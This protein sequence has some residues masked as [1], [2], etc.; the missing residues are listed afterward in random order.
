LVTPGDLMCGECGIAL[1]GDD[2]PPLAEAFAGWEITT[3]LTTSGTARRRHH[4]RRIADGQVGFLTIYA[5]GAQPD[6]DVYRALHERIPREHIA[7]L[8]ESGEFDGRAYDVTELISG[9]TLAEL[10]IDRSDAQTLRR[11]VEELTDALATFMES[12]LRHRSLH[13]EKILVRS[14]E[15]L[16]LVVTGFESARLSEADLE[17]ESL[18]DFSRFTA[19]EAMIGGVASASDW[20]SVGMILLDLATAG[21]CFEGASDQVF[22]IHVQA[23]GAPIPA[24]MDPRI[25]LLLRGLLTIDRTKRWQL[26]EVRDWLD[27]KSPPVTPHTAPG[28]TAQTGPVIRLG[29]LEIRDPRIFATT[30]ATAVHWQQACELLTHGQLALWVEEL[31]LSGSTVAAIRQLGRRTDPAV[32]LRL[33]LALQHLFPAMPLIHNE[34]LVT[35]SWLLVHPEL[36][37]ELIT[38]SIPESLAQLG[39]ASDG[40]LLRL[41]TRLKEVRSRAESL[42]IE[43]DE[44][45]LHGI[46]LI[47]S[48][49]KLISMWNTHRRALPDANHAAL[50]AIVERRN[51]TDEDLVLLLSAAVGQFR[52]CA[53]IFERITKAAELSARPT[54][55]EAATLELLALPRKQIYALVDDR[56]TGFARCGHQKIDSWAD[57]FRLEHRLPLPEAVLLLAYPQE[58]WAKPKHQEYVSSVIGFF[59]KRVSA[60]TQRGPL[61]R[62]TIGKTTPRIDMTELGSDAAKASTLLTSL[63]QRS[64]KRSKIDPLVFADDDGPERRCRTLLNKT[65]QYFR[66]TGVNGAYIGFPFLVRK[67]VRE[68]TTPRLAPILLWPV[69]LA[70]AVGTRGDYTLN[71]DENRGEVRVNPA[72][73]GL[74]GLDGAAKWKELARDLMS[75]SSLTI[76]DVVGAF[77][78]LAEP[79]GIDLEPL[80]AP[81]TLGGEETDQILCSAVL[82]HVEFIG[83]ALVEDLRNLKQRPV[84]ESALERMLRIEPESTSS[85]P[86]PQATLFSASTDSGSRYLVRDSDPSQEEAIAKAGES[87][88]LLIQGPPGT[89]KSQTIVN[90]VADSVGHGRTVLIVCQKLPALEVVRKR[91]EA[92]RLGD[93]IV[94]IT[95]VTKDRMPVL[96]DIRSQLDRL[97]HR[98][99]TEVDRRSRAAE[100]LALQIDK[101]EAEIDAYYNAGFQ[102]DPLNDRTHRQILGELIDVE[103]NLPKPP[104]DVVGLRAV[105]RELSATDVQDVTDNCASVASEWLAACYENSPLHATLAF[106]HDAATIAEYQHTFLR[107]VDAE[108]TRES[109]PAPRDPAEGRKCPTELE[110]WLDHHREDLTG[111]SDAALTAVAPCLASFGPSARGPDY[112]KLLV[113]ANALADDASPPIVV[114]PEF[115]AWAGTITSERMTTVAATCREHAAIWLSA[116]FE[117]SPLEDVDESAAKPENTE[118]FRDG[119]DRLVRAEMARQTALASA[120]SPVRV[121]NPDL[122]DHW[123]RDC[124]EEL[125]RLAAA[126]GRASRDLVPPEMRDRSCTAYAEVLERLAALGS[127][128]RT[129]SLS[130]QP[131]VLALAAYDD[132]RLERISNETALAADLWLSQPFDKT[133]VEAIDRFP[134]S[135]LDCNRLERAIERFV[136][137]ERQRVSHLAAKS[138]DITITEPAQTREWL[139]D[140]DRLLPD[141]DQDLCEDIARWL[142]LYLNRSPRAKST[143]EVAAE[144]DALNLEYRRLELPRGDGRLAET[145]AALDD[146]R[147]DMLHRQSAEAVR[148]LDLQSLFAG[149][150]SRLRLAWWLFTQG[151]PAGADGI[152]RMGEAVRREVDRRQLHKRADAIHVTLNVPSPPRDWASLGTAI[153]TL[154]DRFDIGLRVSKVIARCPC[155]ID[156]RGLLS[157]KRHD[158]IVATVESIRSTLAAHDAEAASLTA[159]ETIRADMKSTWIDFQRLNIQ[160]EVPSDN[161][162]GYLQA[163]L[164]ALPLLRPAA[165]LSQHLLGCDDATRHV[166][167]AL[168]PARPLIEARPPSERAEDIRELVW[169][170]ALLA[171]KQ[172][173]ESDVPAL[174]SLPSIRREDAAASAELLRKVASLAPI[175]ESCPL[176]AAL[177]DSVRAR[178]ATSVTTALNAFQAGLAVARARES[179]LAAFADTSRF[180]LPAARERLKRAI[181]ADAASPLKLDRILQA[182]PTLSAY[183]RFRAIAVRLERDVRQAFQLLSA[184]RADIQAVPEAERADAI[185]RGML[186]ARLRHELASIEA[187]QPELGKLKGSQPGRLATALEVM[188]VAQLL[189]SV[190]RTCPLARPLIAAIQ[191]GTAEAVETVLADYRARIDRAKAESESLRAL[192]TLADWMAPDWLERRREAI[193]SGASSVAEIK[194]LRD[195][196]PTLAA[197]QLFRTR[198]ASLTDIHFKVF[199]VLARVRSGLIHLA[200]HYDGDIGQAIRS[201]MQRESLLAWKQKA[202][203]SNAAITTDSKAIT[204]KVARL[205]SLDADLRTLNR[206]RLGADLPIDDVLASDDWEEITRLQGPR[207]LR[208]RQFFD[209]GREYGLL[210]LRPVWMMTPD[211]ASQ[212][213]PLEKKLFDLV[214]FDEASQMPVEYAI[215]SLYRAT[216]AVVSGDEKQ[217]P[218]SSFFSSRLGL[219]EPE[220]TDDD[221]PEESASDQERELLEQTWNRREVKDCPDLLHLGMAVLPKATLQ[222]HYRSQYRELIAFSNA[223]FYRNELGVPVRHPEETIKITKP[224]EYRAVGG[225]YGKQCNPKEAEAVVDVVA[226]LW[227]TH[228]TDGP[229]A[230]IVTFNLKQA[231]LIE[232]LLEARAEKD[233]AFRAVYA[234]E[235]ERKDGGEDMSFFVKNVENVQGDERDLIIFSTTFGKRSNGTFLRNF[236]VLGQAGGERRLNV[237]ITRARSKIIVV[238]S[239]PIDQIS[240]MLRTKRKPEVPRD[241]LQGFLQYASLLSAGQLQEAM[242]LIDRIGTTKQVAVAIDQDHDGFKK[243]VAAFIRGLGLDPVPTSNDPVLG[244]DF[245]IRN[246]STGLFSVAVQCDPPRHRLLTRARAREIWR[247]AVLSRTY[248]HIHR[249]TAYAWYQDPAG[250]RERLRRELAK[251]IDSKGSNA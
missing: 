86:D 247:P 52:S 204:A 143:V 49:P 6:R 141:A 231:D 39:V 194:A 91:L 208:L 133:L 196:L 162:Q 113:Q 3:T 238:G 119:L 153:S 1:S 138:R 223:A 102:R 183:V 21:A 104:V 167:A 122:L 45:R 224:I 96:R 178:S 199:E 152:R 124:S 64:G 72:F 9:G 192:D 206:E 182:V 245:S 31:K 28:S 213:L 132:Q 243:S 128:S 211:I 29:D 250:E 69:T 2:T 97:D 134:A 48:T 209:R 90:L 159:L 172:Q 155:N 58:T 126:V 80:P 22:L 43:L 179:S 62:M 222:I 18:I 240:D 33:G 56:I 88:G 198:S 185:S 180:L 197:F 61:V 55:D 164:R 46:A 85:L 23:N 227:A 65:T 140:I 154:A 12:G 165:T 215:P 217:M 32:G 27:G 107:F 99:E 176:Q 10:A 40:F 158:A 235:R 82:F 195:A 44:D 175:V 7:E 38:S 190:I 163:L 144:L 109:I 84:D 150:L 210:V 136:Q 129:W 63:L 207:A 111:W 54:P 123:L 35:P 147:L 157:G 177:L 83:Q 110:A 70:G 156:K 114:S 205:G 226:D 76:S 19:P 146:S 184:N 186:L 203:A 189:S 171:R 47:A 98:D 77:A 15:P 112:T 4:A 94:M 25:E 101:V 142:P 241:Y 50:A 145:V 160:S 11:I 89:G 137:A 219:D 34:E 117:G 188:E 74:L 251:H 191:T 200:K 125:A 225:I 135:D 118:H 239:M 187:A 87:E 41:A 59:E 115:L 218:P 237:A 214:V 221:Q 212:V 79:Q 174:R 202:E 68:Q 229:S 100:S 234:A 53:E 51:P 148:S 181:E 230:G 67:P 8:L 57:Q 105:F 248:K 13:P 5:P 93:R 236:G 37:Y 16:D 26:K 92:E 220:W 173:L 73:E 71:F 130:L 106:H 246:P 75:N 24:G 121:D 20:W 249:L 151:F 232:E 95:N 108:S 169:R 166:L 60:S 161:H 127:T 216:S 228:G 120:N 66:D 103:M 201:V 78:P 42:E 139:K 30:A 14:S 233:E 81:S 116:A 131:L 149:R 168:T 193:V 17:T 242:S 36:G 244:V 170:H